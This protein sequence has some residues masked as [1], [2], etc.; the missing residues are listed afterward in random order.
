V[1]NP[2]T[3]GEDDEAQVILEALRQIQ[4]NPELM[5]EAEKDPESLLDRLN[6]S[7]IARN[8]VALG[9]AGLT[10]AQSSGHFPRPQ[11]FWA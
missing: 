7:D 6:L 2:T 8:A 4:H 5:T 3:N 11:G 9:I 1:G 10:V